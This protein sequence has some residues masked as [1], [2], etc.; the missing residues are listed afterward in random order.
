MRSKG[1]IVL[2]I[3]GLLLLVGGCGGVS[4]YNSMVQQQESVRQAWANVESNYQ[5]RADLIPNLVN[6]VQGAA[7]FEQE[8]LT[9]VT[10]ARAR[11]T[12]IQIDADDLDNPEKIQQYQQAQGELG[13]ALGRLL[14]VSENYPTLRATEQ[15]QTL[16]A[17]LEGTENRI[18]VARR[19]YNESVAQYNTEIRSFPTNIIAGITGFQP[20]QP[21]EAEAGAEDAPT[22]SF[23]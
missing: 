6:T 20:R 13:K 15:F 8:T 11:A 3:L 7:D 10:E 16:Q 19:D 2:A 4:S 1:T 18:N 17:Q 12:S 23:D 21:F 5:R 22:V 14:M 9:Q